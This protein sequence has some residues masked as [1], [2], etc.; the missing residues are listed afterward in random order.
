ML[1]NVNAD[2]RT[3]DSL[4]PIDGLINLMIRLNDLRCGSESDVYRSRLTR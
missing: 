4:N 2:S 1:K 3:I